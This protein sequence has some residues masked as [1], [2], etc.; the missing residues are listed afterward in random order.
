MNSQF[1]EEAFNQAQGSNSL[2]NKIRALFR[3]ADP[4]R[5]ATPEEAKTALAKAQELMTRHGIQMASVGNADEQN[6]QPSWDFKKETYQTGRQRYEQDR[7]IYWILEKCFGVKVYFSSY[8]E[9]VDVP[10]R[11]SKYGN[12]SFR[13]TKTYVK[14]HAF[15]LVGDAMDVEVAKMA[16]DFLHPTMRRSYLDFCKA[17]GTK[18]NVR[19]AHTHYQGIMDGYVKASDQGQELARAQ[20]KKK[21][22]DAYSIVLVDKQNALAAFVKKNVKATGG[23]SARCTNG[24]AAAYESGYRTGKSLDIN[25]GRRIA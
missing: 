9:Y 15:V 7:Y 1:T 10:P 25:T 23:T 17:T 2:I 8:S 3:L 21:D 5:G 19:D 13:S 18:F 24:S 16:I 20:A 4:K 11:K 14:R 6:Q 12:T 22:A